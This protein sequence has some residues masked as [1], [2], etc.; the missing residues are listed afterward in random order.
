[1]GAVRPLEDVHSLPT[2]GAATGWAEG[3][4]LRPTFKGM[5][6][7]EPGRAFAEALLEET[8]QPCRCTL[9]L[10]GHVGR[11]T[12]SAIVCA[13]AASAAAERGAHVA[14][15]LVQPLGV[16]QHIVRY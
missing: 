5:H 14:V 12:V 11:T 6:D 7:V 8:R 1:M 10:L 4:L 15:R 16:S 9:S 3:W 13:A 2:S